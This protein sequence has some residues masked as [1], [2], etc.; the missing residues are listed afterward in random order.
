M[1][2]SSKIAVLLSIIGVLIGLYAQFDLYI[3]HF[4]VSGK[5]KALYGLFHISYWGYLYFSLL[6][7]LFSI[8][9]LTLK[10][11]LTTVVTLICLSIVS[12]FSLFHA[13]WRYFI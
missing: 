7:F 9:S 4:K 2:T 3:G 5:T 12:F 6:S 11:K 8:L 10:E 13:W 1:K